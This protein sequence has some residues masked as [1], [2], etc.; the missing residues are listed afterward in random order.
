M[1]DPGQQV[2]TDVLVIGGGIAGCSS[3]MYLAR[4]GVPV[5]L[6]EQHDLHTGASGANAG[7]LHQQ[8]LTARTVPL[9]WDWVGYYA[10]MVRFYMAAVGQWQELKTELDVDI[11]LQVLGGISVAENEADMAVVARKAEL[12]RANGGDSI[13]LS[14]DDLRRMAPYLSERLAGGCYSPGE[15]KANPLLAVSAVSRLAARHG[16][17]FLKQE[18]ALGI[19]RS[20]SGYLVTTTKRRI[21]C[22]RIVLA[23][24]PG[25][26]ELAGHLNVAIPI[27]TSIIQT[28][29][30]EAAAPVMSHLLYH[31]SRPLTMKQVSNGNVVIGGGWPGYS[32]PATG[33][34]L[35]RRESIAAST[36]IAQSV[37]PAVSRMRLL[38]AWAACTFTAADGFPICGAVPGEPG[39]YLVISNGYGFTMG[40]LLGCIIN[41]IVTGRQPSMDASRLR[42]GR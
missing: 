17:R 7:N 26:P 20:D 31:V 11:E 2:E 12:E 36:W 39:F 18:K 22:K 8:I 33:H 27:R 30:T 13:V 6:L 28:A 32:S 23:A 15:G 3:A 35:V 24:G 5:V 16:A 25:A 4:D 21:R 42:V 41:E 9:G 10:G 14:R 34:P 38:R 37:V 40:P 1:T 19:E 29:V